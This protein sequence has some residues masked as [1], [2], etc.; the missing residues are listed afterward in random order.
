MEEKLKRLCELITKESQ[1]RLKTQ[2]LDCECNLNQVVCHYKIGKKYAKI[3][4]RTSGKYMVDLS[5]GKIYGIK[6]YGVININHSF[7]DLDSIDL[8]FW[9]FY[10]AILKNS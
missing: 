2:K 1:E 7:G 6:A 10:N 4:D 9:G 3:D 8:Y 5:S